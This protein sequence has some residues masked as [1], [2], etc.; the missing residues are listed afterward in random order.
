[1]WLCRCGDGE[2]GECYEGVGGGD[3]ALWGDLRPKLRKVVLAV[4][5]SEK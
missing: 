1:V 4:N 2:V 5:K 3:D